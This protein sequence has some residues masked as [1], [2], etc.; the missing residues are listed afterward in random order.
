MLRRFQYFS[1][2]LFVLPLTSNFRSFHNKNQYQQQQND[3]PSATLND[4]SP[5][6]NDDH[7]VSPT[8]EIDLLKDL[9]TKEMNEIQTRQNSASGLLASQQQK[10]KHQQQHRDA[11]TTTNSISDA[12]GYF[13]QTG[14]LLLPNTTGRFRQDVRKSLVSYNNNVI[15]RAKR[16]LF[17]PAN[18]INSNNKIN[19]RIMILGQD[20]AALALKCYKTMVS[21]HEQAS[22]DS[23]LIVVEKQL[24]KLLQTYQQL[25]HHHGVHKKKK[26][27]NLL[28]LLVRSVDPYFAM[29]HAIPDKSLRRV[30]VHFPPP[31]SSDSE[32]HRRIVQHHFLS[33]AHQKLILGGDILVTTDYQPLHKFH[34]EQVTITEAKLSW[35]VRETKSTAAIK[36][37]QSSLIDIKKLSNNK[38]LPVLESFVNEDHHHDEIIDVASTPTLQEAPPR[39]RFQQLQQSP[40]YTLHRFKDMDT[41]DHV[42][43]QNAN[44]VTERKLRYGSLKV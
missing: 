16:D 27:N 1:S 17:S 44:H 33:L 24:E 12:I 40:L 41:P 28:L 8:S 29:L 3:K 6:L 22:S 36:D 2:P 43:L 26:N 13:P 5:T 20:T 37:Q 31:C 19:N 34:E 25:H 21:L 7:D 35:G 15:S 23:L 10:E 30:V 32:S 9:A 11:T 4:V 42:I 18:S 38:K 14:F 39:I